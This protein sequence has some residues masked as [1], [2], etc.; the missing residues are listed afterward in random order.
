MLLGQ[1]AEE[2]M[3][4]ITSAEAPLN[5]VPRAT[6][7]VQ[8]RR[9]FGLAAVEALLTYLR[10]LGISELYLSPLFR[11]REESSHGYDVVDHGA[12]DPE[13]GDI[14]GFQSLAEAARAADMGVVLDVV[15][16]HMGINDPGNR[17]WLDVLMHGPAADHA[18][19][20]DIDWHPPA[21][22]LRNKVLLPFLGEPF[23]SV[24]E[25]GQLR[26]VYEHERLQVAYGPMRF[27]L[28]TAT[29][30]AELAP[31]VQQRPVNSGAFD[32]ALAEFNGQPGE[33]RSF[34]RLE[35]LL[36]EQ[37]YRLAFWRVAADEINYRRFF[38]INDLAAIRVEDPRVFRD[39]HAL[40]ARFLEE[41]WVTGLRIDHPDGLFDPAAYFDNLQKLY[42]ESVEPDSAYDGS[43]EKKLYV[44]AEK[45]LS[46]D[47]MLPADWAVSGSTGYDL[48]NLVNRV[49]VHPEGLATLRTNY[50]RLTGE[51]STAAETM[52]ESKREVL[53]NS[54]ASEVQMLVSQL[55]RI[56][57]QNRSSRDF[58]RPLLVRGLREVM[59][60]LP[61]YRTYVRPRGWEVCEADY[62][63]VATAVRLAKRRNPGTSHAVFDFIGAVLRLEYAA[64]LSAEQ[65]D[66]WRQFA[67]K[68][69]QVTGP[70]MAKG[71]EDTAFYRYFPLASLNE[72]GA[73]LDARPLAV[74]EFHALMQR[75]AAQW[76]HSMSASATHDTKRGEDMRARLHVLA[77]VA[78]DWMTAVARWHEVVRPF[79]LEIDGEA[80]PDQNDLYLLYQTLVGSWPLASI[81][82]AAH[83]AGQ[84]GYRDRIVAYM[85]KALRE[86]KRRT[87]WM[88]PAEDYEAAMEQLV[89]R[90]LTADEGAAFRVDVDLFVRRIAPAGY[91]NGLSQLVL[92]MSLPGVPDFY[93]G[94]EFWDFNLVDP[95]NRRPVDYDARRR[96]MERLQRR[97]REAPRQLVEELAADLSRDEVKQFV[98]WRGLEARRAYAPT[99][100][101]GD[102]QPL[103][104]EGVHA[105]HVLAFTRQFEDRWIAAIVPR[106]IE[107]LRDVEGRLDWGDAQ[108]ELPPQVQRWRHALT[109][110]EFVP[111][112]AIPVKELLAPLSAALL[113]SDAGGGSE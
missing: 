84:G 54:L 3:A 23:G 13:F 17:W 33:P 59:A 40:V 96:S 107:Y 22:H 113:T 42:R 14:A 27:P 105:T 29:W 41:G 75:R 9:G 20:F 18:D 88:N 82:E 55:E 32:A 92:K 104:V 45:I 31:L 110:Q 71:L 60:C 39:V 25:S 79:R 80:A 30:P 81:A 101:H 26:V 21:A 108:V 58:T 111:R 37:W 99:F 51:E 72:V 2:R 102:Y 83:G 63:H 46:G 36:D 97:F 53:L 90:L 89:D 73:E 24:L 38:D 65:I 93:R 66:Q 35:K 6:Y 12:I 28:A 19:Y 47:E 94:T 34:D 95:D 69:Q 5:R 67:L 98:T 106:Q 48:L 112:G 87:S 8:L 56:A 64:T 68:V 76:P 62:R 4:G 49:L 77:E 85:R 44:L 78:D 16:N 52:Y 57:R 15:P 86:A 74:E 43:S 50:E 103:R 11:S 109:G 1:R 100:A 70:A 10:D 91:V 61:V 7:R